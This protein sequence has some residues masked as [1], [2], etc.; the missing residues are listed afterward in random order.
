MGTANNVG[1]TAVFAMLVIGSLMGNV[2]F[3]AMLVI[4]VLV[5]SVVIWRMSRKLADK[6]AK[7]IGRCL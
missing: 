1:L 7:L 2:V 6:D 3:T 4:L 5:G